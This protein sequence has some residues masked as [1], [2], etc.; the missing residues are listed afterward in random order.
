MNATSD[1]I[2]GFPCSHVTGSSGV[3]YTVVGTGIGF[4]ASTCSNV[5]DFY[6]TLSV[7]SGDCSELRCLTSD[8][9]DYGV[10]CGPNPYGY[11]ASEV[12]WGTVEGQI[13]FVLVEGKY[14][15]DG[16]FELRLTEFENADNDLCEEALEVSVN[17]GAIRASTINATAEDVGEEVFVLALYQGLG[18]GSAL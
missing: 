7:F 2:P 6:A 11:G 18:C 5:T 12:S 10:Y 15:T 4:K 3:W 9:R 8:T 1:L 17:G 13:Y 14:Q 16:N